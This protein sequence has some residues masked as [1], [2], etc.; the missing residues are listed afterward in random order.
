[1]VSFSSSED[2]SSMVSVKETNFIDRF[3]KDF[4]IESIYNDGIK[5]DI[6]TCFR[7]GIEKIRFRIC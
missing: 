4:L 7:V 5:K 1:M 2:I 6:I 3:I